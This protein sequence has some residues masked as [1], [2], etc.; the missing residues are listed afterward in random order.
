MSYP[1]LPAADLV[2]RAFLSCVLAFA[3]PLAAG[4]QTIWTGT[5]G[6]WFSAANWSLGVP[7]SSATAEIDNGGTAEIAANGAAAHS[8]TLGY[9]VPDSGYLTASGIGT[10]TVAA[11][12]SVGYGGTGTLLITDGAQVSDYSGEIGYTINSGTG[13]TGTATV[14]G[15]GSN[16]T[17]TYELYVGYGT[18]TLNILSGA[19]VSDYYGY[20]GYYPESPGRSSGTANVDG[21]GS[22]WSHDSTFIVGASGTGVMNVTNGG[23]VVNGEGDLGFGFGSDGTANIDGAGSLWSTN[24]F[25][26]IGQ[27]GNGTLHVTNGGRAES[28]GSYA[29]VGYTNSSTSQA[30]I[31][32][33]GSVWHNDHG[34]YVGFDGSGTIEIT[35]GGTLES[36]F[37]A[38]IGFSP[39]AS[40]TVSLSGAGSHFANAG[41]LAVG[42]NVGGSGGSGLLQVGAGASVDADSIAV[43]NTGSVE[44]GVAPAASG[45][46]HV[47]STATLE[48]PLSI[49]FDAGTYSS[50]SYTLLQVDGGLAG[51]TFPTVTIG[52]PPDGFQAE[53]S[54]DA[55]HVYLVLTPAGADLSV[56]PPSV[57]FGTV[58]AGVT[59]GP[60]TFTLFSSGTATVTV[61]ALADATAPFVRAGGDCP[62]P[63]FDLASGVSC[64]LAYSFSPTEVG[65]A[66]DTITITSSVGSRTIKLSGTGI[67]GVPTTLVLVGGSGQSTL[68]GTSFASPLAARVEDD[69][70]NPVP[71]VSVTFTAPSSGASAVLS[72]TSVN[73][74]A[75]G[76]ASV[77]AIAND[78]AGTYDVSANGGLGSPIVFTLTN[79]SAV[80]DV[81][82]SIDAIGYAERGQTIDYSVTIMNS[83]PN[84][85]TGVAVASALSPLLDVANA[86]WVCSGPAGSGCT[87]SGQGNLLDTIDIPSGGSV[88]YVISASVL[89][90]ADD[91]PIETSVTATLAGDPNGANN[92]AVATTAVVIFRNGFD[93]GAGAVADLSSLADGHAI[94]VAV[95]P[96]GVGLVDTLLTVSRGTDEAFRVERLNVGTGAVRV[97]AR[98]RDGIERQG[99][100]IGAP[101]RSTL[102]VDVIDSGNARIARLRDPG[103]GESRVTIDASGL[104][105]AL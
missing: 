10:L 6:D 64:T 70:G 24:G 51:A 78:Q 35:N 86:S 3:F 71:N 59:A 63:P 15:A 67:A 21:A 18:G 99:P 42:G 82:V 97:V 66:S 20:L 12:I 95:P 85:A 61:S 13:A 79:T 92:E 2:R 29:Y 44:I 74:D 55:N 81:G 94:H 72:A 105:P 1:H 65:P 4:A 100:W 84:D 9:D 58:P 87:A 56:E 31:D 50:G 102:S 62:S 96:R 5:S 53:V 39:G 93:S 103:S 38:N 32:G 47:S 46:I 14:Q 77:T 45:S 41:A 89:P 11:D 33:T 88:S 23:S 27:N 69:W 30:T 90:D 40:G 60:A 75:D 19:T 54:Y 25:F 68:V 8:I 73:T 52:T 43:W 76:I 36:G 101:A 49:D 91:G 104:K 80:S 34:L 37:F 98:D 17:N 83:G 57:D 7:D 22:T 16:W 28:H 26:Y 48:G